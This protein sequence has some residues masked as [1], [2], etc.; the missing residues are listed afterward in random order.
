[1]SSAGSLPLPF[2]LGSSIGFG[3]TKN[4]RR[5][6]KT[7]NIVAV[8]YSASLMFKSVQGWPI[9]ALIL[10]DILAFLSIAVQGCPPQANARN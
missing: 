3:A 7:S 6:K 4:D 10:K 2:C 1:M 8:P 9:S 5:A